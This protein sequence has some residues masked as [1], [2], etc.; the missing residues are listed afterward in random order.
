MPNPQ[1]TGSVRT[2]RQN[3]QQSV[4][5]ASVALVLALLM[6]SAVLLSLRQEALL[7][8]TR[9]ES[10]QLRLPL[11]DTIDVVREHLFTMRRTVE[12]GLA[13]PSSG[14]VRSEEWKPALGT[15]HRDPKAALDPK[16]L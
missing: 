13:Q 11:E 4:L 15:L 3:Y 5:A 6:S 2:L 9:G 7:A 1:H 8:T 14:V 12:Y 10:A 16:L